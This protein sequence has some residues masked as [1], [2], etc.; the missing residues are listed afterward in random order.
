MKRAANAVVINLEFCKRCDTQ[1]ELSSKRCKQLQEDLFRLAISSPTGV[2]EVV[3]R[4]GF[5]GGT[6]VGTKLVS[7]E[8]TNDHKPRCYYPEVCAIMRSTQSASLTP[9]GCHSRN[10]NVK[11]FRVKD[12]SEA[13]MLWRTTFLPCRE[14]RKY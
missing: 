9:L 2:L 11:K 4:T 14:Q 7:I 8:V 10:L 1:N 13:R 3:L 12:K 6:Q 5:V